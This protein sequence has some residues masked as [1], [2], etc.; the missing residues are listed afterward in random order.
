MTLGPIYRVE[1]WRIGPDYLERPCTMAPKV[2]TFNTTAL[3]WRVVHEVFWPL[4]ND[5]M[6]GSVLSA[7]CF[8]SS[9]A[10]RS[11]GSLLDP[12]SGTCQ[13]QPSW[14]QVAM[15]KTGVTSKALRPLYS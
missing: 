5:F 11:Q 3:K 9:R 8:T 13:K 10:H 1:A 4:L 15:T 14:K 12:D 2:S 6:V 7:N